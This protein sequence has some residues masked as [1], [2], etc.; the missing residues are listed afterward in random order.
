MFS[1]HINNFTVFLHHQYYHHEFFFVIQ[2]VFEMKHLRAAQNDSVEQLTL[3]RLFS[4]KNQEQLF[5]T[6]QLSYSPFGCHYWNTMFL[7]LQIFILLSVNGSKFIY[8]FV[9]RALCKMNL[10]VTD[11]RC[12]SFDGTATMSA[13]KSAV[14]T[15]I[16]STSEQCFYTYCYGHVLKLAVGYMASK[17]ST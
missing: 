16:K 8:F 9:R 15:R 3:L 4:T 14:T 1:V 11:V 6:F 10:D 5:S 17:E 12:Q 7:L 2:N 13:I